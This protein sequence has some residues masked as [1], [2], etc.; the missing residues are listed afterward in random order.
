VY[1][2]MM[3]LSRKIRNDANIVTETMSGVI[4][5]LMVTNACIYLAID[6]MECLV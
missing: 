2:K 3:L 6:A 1:L 5:M 4:S